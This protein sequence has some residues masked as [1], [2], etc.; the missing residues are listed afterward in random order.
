[1]GSAFGNAAELV[2]LSPDV[3]VTAGGLAAEALRNA[4]QTLPIVFANVGDPVGSGPVASLAR[5]GGNVTGFMSNEFGFSGINLKTA[6]AL[7]LA[8]PPSLLVL[9]TEVIE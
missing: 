1:M 5:P 9:A 8:I 4:T 3:L 7:G 2:A 6:R